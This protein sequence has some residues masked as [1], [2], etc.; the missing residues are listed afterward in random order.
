MVGRPPRVSD[1]DVY[2]AVAQVITDHGPTG[3]TLARVGESVGVTAAALVQRFGSK[4][5]LL[6]SFARRAPSATADI[7]DHATRR[8]PAPLDALGEALDALVLPVETPQQLANHLAFLCVDLTDED[9]NQA[10]RQQAL[11]FRERVQQL[12]DQAVTARTLKPI[13]TRTLA[14]AVHTAWNGALITWALVGRGPVRATVTR[15]VA[16]IL[17]PHR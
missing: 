15:A 8:M 1:D 12:L 13:D 10:A 5:A 2:A 4:R 16:T 3:L 9:F 14:E 7:F 17:D 6:L 11:I